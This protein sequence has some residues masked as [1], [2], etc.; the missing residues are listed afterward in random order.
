MGFTPQQ[1]NAMSMW[2]FRMA[3]DGYVRANAPDDGTLTSA[4]VDDVWKWLNE[5]GDD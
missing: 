5:K 1:I 3:L 4:E 2:Q